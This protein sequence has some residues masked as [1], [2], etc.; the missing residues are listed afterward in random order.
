MPGTQ[1]QEPATLVLR[2]EGPMALEIQHTSDVI[3][4][5][6]NR[7]FGWNA[8]GRIALRQA[9]LSRRPVRQRR[10]APDAAALVVGVTALPST[11]VGGYGGTFSGVLTITVLLAFLQVVGL[12]DAGQQIAYGA[13]L[14]LM[15]MRWAADVLPGVV[16]GNDSADGELPSQAAMSARSAGV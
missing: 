6:V 3:I 15:L 8:V 9:P 1:P 13:V 5:R 2:V 16:S 11:G 10:K 12:S 7:F 4:E 14:L